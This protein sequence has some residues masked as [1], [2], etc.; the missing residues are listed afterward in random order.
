MTIWASGVMTLQAMPM[1]EPAYRYRTSLSAFRTMYA[2]YRHRLTITGAGSRGS[3]RAVGQ[4]DEVAGG[5]EGQR[6][7]R[8]EPGQRL[9]LGH[10]GQQGLGHLDLAQH[11]GVADADHAGVLGRREPDAAERGLDRLAV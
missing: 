1:A 10:L 8:A 4:A 5:V 6:D 3:R 7:R 11:Q 2:R 9:T